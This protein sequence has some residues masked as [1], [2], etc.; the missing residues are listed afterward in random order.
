MDIGVPKEC[1]PLEY[2]VGLSPAVV[3]TLTDKGHRVV[4]ET[5]C[6]DGS[7]FSDD[8]YRQAG[9]QVLA[10]AAEI[11]AA[12]TLIVKVK[13]PQPQE[14]PLLSEKH[15]LF[16]YLHLAAAPQLTDELL[17]RGCTAIAYETV[18]DDEG[19]LPL[20]TPMSRIAGRMA[21]QVGAHYLEKP[22]GRGVLMSGVD[23][24]PA[25]NVVILG[26]GNVGSQAAA[27]ALGMGANVTLFDA[28]EARIAQLNQQFD[29]AIRCAVADPHEVEKAVLAADLVIGSV[30]IP[31]AAT[32]VLVS[33]SVVARMASGAVLVD[34]AI[35]QGGC[36]A[37][38]KTT[39]LDDPVFVQSDVIHYCVS[40]M[41]S[42]VSRT[43]TLALNQM[44]GPWVLAMAEQGVEKA[45]ANSVHLQRGVN[46]FRGK[47]VHPAVAEA[48][49]KTVHTLELS[50]LA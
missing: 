11:Y 31:G 40:N 21:A 18:T 22:H 1:K 15:T 33:E 39:H 29:G 8:D 7:G 26:G 44:T 49:G 10:T 2:R 23:G 41:P 42:A 30:L 37:T 36:F 25:A 20:L 17:A 46:I 9:A 38:S 43:S 47:I 24:A 3:R 45:L 12:A 4:V 6:G 48:L 27:T 19:H 28:V 16:T 13:E 50:S 35:D 32:P 34:V 5:G 14:Y